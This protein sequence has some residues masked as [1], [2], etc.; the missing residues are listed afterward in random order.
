MRDGISA[1]A[2]G[3]P[4]PVSL[5]P[6]DVLWGMLLL[7]A[8]FL[9]YQPVWRAGYI[10]D[11]P[12]LL[13]ANPCIVGPL[14]LKEVWT[15][16]AA[17]IC[18]LTITTLWAEHALW[19]LTPLPFHLVNVVLHAACAIVLWRVL[20]ILRVPGAW[21]GAALWA[22]HPVQVDSAA[23]V[24]EM[25]N[26]E[27]GLFFLLAVL[28]FV[29]GLTVDVSDQR[30]G[31]IWNYGW[32]LLFAALA[33]AG[34][35]STVV[36]PI[37]LCLCA[38]WMEG[39]WRWRHLVPLA[40]I[41]LMS[42]AAGLISIWTQ[43]IQGAGDPLWSLSFPQRLAAAGDAVWFYLGKLIWPHPLVAVY[44]RW[45]ID[46]G[47][48][49]AYLPLLAVVVFTAIFWLKRTSWARPYLFAWSL[50]LIALFPILGFFSNTFSRYS[51]AADHFQYLA[52]M[53]PLALAGAGLTTLAGFLLPG[54]TGLPSFLA[55]GL[56]V[57]LGS[58]T[59]QRAWV[60]QNATT[61]WT[62][63]VAKN[64][65]CWVGYN[66]L[67]YVFMEEGKL[68][69]AISKFQKAAALN[70]NYADAYNNLG[71]AYIQKGEAD[72]AI[73]QC[74]QALKINPNIA[75]AHVIIGLALMQ[76]GRIADAISEY[77]KALYINPIFA[78][79]H[80]KLGIAFYQQ[81]RVDDAILQFQETLE[82]NPNN[83]DAQS[84][85]A[86]ALLQKGQL[87]EA[88]VHFQR[89][90]QLNPH[91]GTTHDNL[92]ALLFR[93]GRLDE[94]TAQYENALQINSRDS[95]AHNNLGIVLAKKGRWNDA[96]AEYQKAL[97][98]D[99][100]L[101]PARLDLGLM[102]ARQGRLDEAIA[103]Y[104]AALGISP[105]YVEALNNL[106]I[107]LYA[108]GQP[109][110][111]AVQYEKVL[112]INPNDPAAHNNLGFILAQKGQFDEAIAQIQEALRLKPDYGDAQTNLAKTEA[113]AARHGASK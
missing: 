46:A 76:K 99:P 21:L 77:Q 60:Y 5:L 57:V 68:D 27:S 112:E 85:L 86:S 95:T 81:R 75:P 32:T 69:P 12:M 48:P 29:K 98:I 8:V 74:E 73:A 10:W 25:K 31:W 53:A 64:H 79:G 111:A 36:L 63:T 35:S 43:R 13:T 84:N 16:A 103:Q 109:D 28:F 93:E 6:R 3:R 65:D 45:R 101:A 70:P 2:A 92:G 97:A 26:T 50:F 23:W 22:L 80:S 11:D 113:M 102:L 49:L 59:W 56:L 20:R 96:T 41:F 66:D 61:F 72:A 107:A 7:A 58:L 51:L 105:R 108:R 19:G 47:H 106:G 38:W 52:A 67:G 94:A 24:T 87:D 82:I 30:R 39:R 100:G 44:P 78:E 62:D 18:P 37:I 1:T 104:R 89:A 4:S 17:D 90:L 15:T 83:A 54:K 33:M 91:D 71:S 110:Q 40:P 34:K 42:L 55:T 14:G 9:A 88:L